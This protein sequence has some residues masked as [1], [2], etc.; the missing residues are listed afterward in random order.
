MNS[1]C[2]L[3]AFQC[4]TFF[5]SFF[6][7]WANPIVGDYPIVFFLL[8]LILMGNGIFVPNVLN[9]N[10]IRQLCKQI[11]Y[12]SFIPLSLQPSIVFLTCGHICCCADCCEPI[13]QCPLCR[14]PVVQKCR[15]YR[16]SWFAR[17]GY[18]RASIETR[19][20]LDVDT[21]LLGREQ[22]CLDVDTTLLGREQRCFN[23]EITSCLCW[24]SI[25]V[26]WISNAKLTVCSFISTDF[27]MTIWTVN[28][29]KSPICNQI[30]NW[31]SFVTLH[32]I[33]KIW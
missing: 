17:G 21:T 2:R 26:K 32:F 15:L 27:Y 8:Q 20:R 25:Q 5:G 10:W 31:C 23:V 24:L 9:S 33:K 3:S 12:F 29:N 7:R 1:S 6:S 13:S 11:V 4:S 18:Y 28:Y 30:T 16:S 14:Q 19:R 22:R